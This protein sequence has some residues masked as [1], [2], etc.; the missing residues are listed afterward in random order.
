MAKWRTVT[1]LAV[2]QFVMVLDS[3][4]MNVSISQIVADLD[5]SVAGIQAAIAFYTLT[6]AAF[7]LMGAK[8]GD[9]YGRRKILAIGVVIY[10][11]GSFMT[12]ISQDI[13]QLMIGWSLIEGLGAVL[14]IPAILALAAVNYNIRFLAIRVP[15]RIPDNGPGFIVYQ[16]R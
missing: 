6:M 4:V 1:L 11:V 10:G 13:A 5:T 9:K 3:T 7:M 2:I 8:L 14:V 12:G 16:D 15:E